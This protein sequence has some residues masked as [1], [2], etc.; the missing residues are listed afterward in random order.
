[1]G[2]V[3]LTLRHFR[4]F[5]ELTINPD[6]SAVTVFLS[7]NGTG[8][9]SVLEA[10]H[11]LGT[12]RSFRTSTA[13]DVIATGHRAAEIHGLFDHD[14]RRITV[15]FTITRGERS[16]LKKMLINGQ[17]PV[18]QSAAADVVPLSVFT[19]DGV[20]MIRRG[21]E[22]RRDFLTDHVVAIYPSVGDVVER[23]ERVL[24]QRNSI[25]RAA[26][27]TGPT[28]F[29]RT[30][31]EPWTAQLIELAE[32]YSRHRERLVTE[33]IPRAD[34]AYRGLTDS[35]D[36]LTLRY[37][38]GWSGDIREALHAAERE[39]WA[40]G[41]T[42]V[43]PHRDDIAVAING[44]DARRQASQ[45]EQRS[46]A[47][48]LRLA[49]HHHH[50]AIRHHRPLLLLDDVF[51]ELDPQRCDRLLHLLPVGQTLLTTASPLPGSMT[52]AS[53]LDVTGATRVA[54]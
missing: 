39:E 1:V 35:R 7:P 25:L 44:R 34:Q 2:L 42:V 47:L 14:G 21:P 33:L 23:Y 15:D 30:E 51:S 38:Y 54:P 27:E 36:E 31:L 43:G 40:R 4:L 46:A 45:G 20:D 10:I 16:V 37:E 53:L 3:S 32:T 24:R 26:R 9:T 6:A 29:A 5:E 19:P 41:M 48:A 17:R 13:G 49:A 52:P 12:G 11:F 28:A 50:E 22:N 8:K 18:N